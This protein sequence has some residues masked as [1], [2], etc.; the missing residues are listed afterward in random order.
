VLKLPILSPARQRREGFFYQKSWSFG[1]IENL[2]KEPDSPFDQQ[3]TLLS[4]RN[5]AHGF[6]IPRPQEAR[7]T[8]AFHSRNQPTRLAG[9]A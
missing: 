3:K 9:L 1:E 6:S 7:E 5:L 8:V 4:E 2:R